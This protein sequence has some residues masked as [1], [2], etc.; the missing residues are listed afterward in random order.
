MTPP[1]G[2]AGCGTCTL[3]STTLVAVSWAPYEKLAARR[4][5]MGWEF[6]WY[7]SS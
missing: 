2:S 7:S 6:P 4:E 3:R 1:T 5:R